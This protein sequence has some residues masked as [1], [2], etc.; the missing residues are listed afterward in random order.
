MFLPSRS[1]TLYWHLQTIYTCI[2]YVTGVGVCTWETRY[3]CRLLESLLY[4]VS[5]VGI[6][7]KRLMKLSPSNSSERDQTKLGWHHNSLAASQRD[8]PDSRQAKRTRIIGGL[9]HKQPESSWNWPSLSD[10]MFSGYYVLTHGCKLIH[11]SSDLSMPDAQW[12]LSAG[13][14]L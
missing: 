9:L 6:T 4:L 3:I 7:S 1:G 5:C 8:H 13:S 10:Q 12:S 11:R 14:W 2:T